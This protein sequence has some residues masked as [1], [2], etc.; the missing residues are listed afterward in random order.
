MSLISERCYYAGWMEGLEFVLWEAVINGPK[1]YRHDEI[2][3]TD[4]KILKMLSEEANCWIVFD[5]KTLETAVE[6]DEWKKSYN[7]HVEQNN[8][9]G[10]DRDLPLN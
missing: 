10:T 2:S 1:P 5:D 3:A 4:I 9:K 6:L 8:P 7:N